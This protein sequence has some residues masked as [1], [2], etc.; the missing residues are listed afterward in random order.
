MISINQCK[1]IEQRE[2]FRLHGPFPVFVHGKTVD[3]NVFKM[4]TLLDNVSH[5]GLYL[6]LPYVLA[7]GTGL[8]AYTRL[9]SGAKLAAKGRVLRTET[10]DDGLVGVALGFKHTR[11]F[12][13]A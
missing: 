13:A 5:G 10:K 9:P 8:F 7:I 4:F 11:V 6:Q 3:G 2:A 12:A 1:N